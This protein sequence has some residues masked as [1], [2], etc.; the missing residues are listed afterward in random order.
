MSAQGASPGHAV[1]MRISLLVCAFS[2]LQLSI[3]CACIVQMPII[4]QGISNIPRIPS[5]DSLPIEW[6]EA[7]KA[8][9][10]CEVISNG[11]GGIGIQL[12]MDFG[13]E[14]YNTWKNLCLP[15]GIEPDHLGDS[16]PNST[17]APDF[18]AIPLSP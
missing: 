18:G 16:D 9:P 5:G 3:F 8:K 10:G 6:I 13:G 2:L 12:R 4:N 1:T 14:A 17:I 7:I 15:D 11:S